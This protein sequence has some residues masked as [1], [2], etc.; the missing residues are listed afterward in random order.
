VSLKVSTRKVANVTIV[1]LS[2]KIVLGK[3]SGEV[4]DAV[5][6]L[7]LKGHKRILLNLEDVDYVDSSGLAELVSSL[8][9]TAARGGALKLLRVQKKVAE[10]MRVTKISSVFEV[11]DHE[12]DALRSFES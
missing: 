10:A 9:S 2:G 12:G 5:R 4:R 1:D 11:F 3:H 8:T 7:L 6:E